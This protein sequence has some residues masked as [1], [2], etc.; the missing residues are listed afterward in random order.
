LVRSPL[1]PPEKSSETLPL[2]LSHFGIQATRGEADLLHQVS[3]AFSRFPYEN[4]TKVLKKA[5]EG[6]AESSRR[7]P[8]E[9][10]ADHV[11]HGAGGTC[12][13]LTAALLHLL[14][15]LGFRAEPLLA[16]RHYGADTHCA[17]SVWFGGVPHLLDLGFLIVRPVPLASGGEARVAT[18]FNEVVLTPREGAKLDLETVQDGKRVLRLTFKTAPAD[19]GAF[20]RAWDAS[21]DWDMMRY[22]LLTRIA[23]GSQLYLHQ[24]RLQVRTRDGASSREVPP[25]ELAARIAEDFGLDPAIVAHAL[26][27]LRRGGG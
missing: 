7:W 12:F 17:L 10:V 2:F 3:L 26:E 15:A 21:F 24:T 22:P 19:P 25:E 6:S 9:V 8:Q 1:D 4:L 13:S 20:L 11:A 14:R 16:D 5:R 18:G 23:E 27:V